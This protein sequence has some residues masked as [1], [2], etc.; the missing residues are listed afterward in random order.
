MARTMKLEFSQQDRQTLATERYQH[1]DP[2]VQQRFEVLHLIS[3]GIPLNEVGPLA[4]VSRATAAR[5]IAIYRQGGLQA[6]RQ[7]HWRKPTSA[8]MDHRHTLEDS[9]RN[10]PPHTIAEACE[11]IKQ[12]T[13]IERRPT[14]VRMFLKKLA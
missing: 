3:Q 1:P 13:G 9:F 5:Y 2:R 6:L 7:F 14:Q 11:R 8:L 10:H 12:L 4:G